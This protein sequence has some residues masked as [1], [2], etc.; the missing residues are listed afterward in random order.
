MN[1]SFYRDVVEVSTVAVVVVGADAV[2]R[3]QSPEASQLLAGPHTDLVGKL[4]PSLFTPDTQTQVDACIR[5][6]VAADPRASA[7]VEATC[8]RSEGDERSIEMTA[9]NLLRSP[10]VEGIVLNLVDRTELRRALSH[11]EWQARF[12][13]LTGL[14]NRRTLEERGRELYR[15]GN[16]R[17]ALVAMLGMDSLK[18]LNDRYGHQAGDKALQ[19]VAH[20]LA[21]A[22]GEFGMVARVGGD[23]FAVLLPDASPGNARTLLD[24]ALQAIQLPLD[25]MDLRITASITAS[26][27]V[28][29]ST[30]AKHWPGLF[31]RADAALYEAKI[32][33]PG[34]IYFDRGDE[35]RWEVRRRRE[36]EALLE[37][38]E[39]VA[40]LESDIVRLEHETRYDERTGLLNY[41]A[42]GEDLASLHALAAQQGDPY[43]I[44]LCDIDFFHRYN[45]R[46]LYQ[47][48]NL[49]LRRVADA[50]K[51]ACRAG[52]VVY[53]YGGEE[54]TVILPRTA[55]PD[56][57]GLGERLR[58]AV[59]Q[60]AIPHEN[61][62][63]PA[64]IVTI[65]AGVA[66][67][68]PRAGGTPDDLI[69]AANR[70]LLAAKASGRNR[71]AA[72]S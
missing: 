17:S 20:R 67:W 5:R 25:G 8:A 27:G 6:A 23:E 54:M 12:D 71:V 21:K 42:F 31:Q 45:E 10:D 32:S 53:R 39:K 58:C 57:M 34:G 46:Y 9:V 70:A 51:A 15:D 29:S 22:I 36:R 33:K 11:A 38:E 19:C 4:F 56:A 44:V 48:A 26:C 60:L 40:A 59:A 16:K 49:T 28:A 55:L 3:Y 68:D 72:S 50:L 52:D 62:P 30:M 1:T 66:V 69:T 13:S 37:A 41:A 18:E 63:D 43:A 14:A 35:P 24:T 61:R 64:T 47:P 2:V 7:S 65:S